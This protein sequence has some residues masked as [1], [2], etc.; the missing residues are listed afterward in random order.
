MTDTTEINISKLDK[1]RALLDK[2]ES[3]ASQF[4][5]EAEALT[6]KAI[7]LMEVY[8]IDEA[9]IADAKPL[10][11]R[12]KI[13]E[14]EFSIGS[15]PYVNA[16]KQ[17]VVEIAASHSVRALESTDFKGKTVYLIGYQTDVELT[18]M[19]YTSLLVQATS[20]MYSPEVKASKPGIVH[21]RAFNRSFLLAFAHR[22]GRRLLEAKESA[23]ASVVTDERSVALVLADRKADV[24]AD[25]FRRYGNIPSVPPITASSSYEGYVAGSEAAD[26]AD[27]GIDRR[28]ST[29]KSKALT[30]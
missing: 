27:L 14:S 7:E 4:P 21:G 10:E 18:E 2:A 15:G 13:I 12:G 29:T 23:E 5:Q 6:A 9:M 22:I 11:D 30:S 28:V 20:T 3:T 16:R 19:L 1:I 25:V 26:R 17:L 8:R 24:D